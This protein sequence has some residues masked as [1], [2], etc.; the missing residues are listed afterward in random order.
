M[1]F[2]ELPGVTWKHPTAPLVPDKVTLYVDAA[3]L[4]KYNLDALSK[5]DLE[6]IFGMEAP[7]EGQHVEAEH[8]AEL[9]VIHATRNLES[10]GISLKSAPP[11]GTN[12]FNAGFGVF[13]T[14]EEAL[15]KPALG[16][17]GSRFTISCGRTD[18]VALYRFKTSEGGGRLIKM[19]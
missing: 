14:L 13:P 18:P 6:E 10:G 16:Y 19:S 5:G 8:R 1:S 3:H 11:A 17:V 12:A 7:Q 2:P 4:A 9:G 15:R